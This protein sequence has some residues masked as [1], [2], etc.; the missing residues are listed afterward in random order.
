MGL[1]LHPYTRSKKLTFRYSGT[2][3]NLPDVNFRNRRGAT[4]AADLVIPNVTK[5]HV[6][7]LPTRPPIH[8]RVFDGTSPRILRSET[9]LE[10]NVLF[11]LKKFFLARCTRSEVAIRDEI[12]SVARQA[13]VDV[14]NPARFHQRRFL[15]RGPTFVK[16]SNRKKAYTAAYLAFVPAGT[17]IAPQR[18]DGC[19]IPG[20]KGGP[21]IFAAWGMS[22]V[23]TLCWH[24]ILAHKFSE[25][26]IDILGS[27]QA[28]FVM[29]E[30]ENPKV[31]QRE[32]SSHFARQ[33]SCT[34]KFEVACRLQAPTKWRVVNPKTI[35]P[36]LPH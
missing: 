30:L 4:K 6:L 1:L 27:K 21:A 33:L 16:R 36:I 17:T 32:V 14:V 11:V 10:K 8:D 28:H 7:V 35:G 24:C 2:L 25:R 3:F 34:I 20:W 5:R 23:E 18:C 13:R 26:V 31:A 9:N 15:D 29:A 19:D 12:I 22:G